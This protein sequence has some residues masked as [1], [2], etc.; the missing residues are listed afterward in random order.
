[1]I[2]KGVKMDDKLKIFVIA[3]RYAKS[4]DDC[5][6]DVGFGPSIETLMNDVQSRAGVNLTDEEREIILGELR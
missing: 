5:C 4:L 2:I 1:M 3:V 6:P